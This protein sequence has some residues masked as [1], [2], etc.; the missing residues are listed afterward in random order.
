MYFSKSR[1][2]SGQVVTFDDPIIPTKARTSCENSLSSSR[3][4]NWDAHT[5]SSQKPVFHYQSVSL[6]IITLSNYRI[7]EKIFTDRLFVC[8]V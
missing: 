6:S 5:N 2:K 1:L 7:Y 8:P 4:Y 3:L